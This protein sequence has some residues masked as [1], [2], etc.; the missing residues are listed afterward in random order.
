MLLLLFSVSLSSESFSQ[1]VGINE[2]GADPDAS[3]ILDLSATNKGLL[4]PRLTSLQRDNIGSPAAG[5][6]IYNV[7]CNEL[8]LYNGTS[9]ID[10]MGN[11]SVG[12]PATPVATSATNIGQTNFDANWTASSGATSYFIDVDD[13]SDFSSPVSG[14][15]NLN[16]GNVTT[17]FI[18]GLTCATNYYYRVGASNS[19]NTGT[20]SGTIT[21]TTTGCF[22]GCISA[23]STVVQDVTN[24]STGK[25]W[26]DRNLGASQVATASNDA[27][28]Y[29]C[30]YQWGRAADGHEDRGSATTAVL[31]GTDSP[32]HNNFITTPSTPGDWRNPKNDNLWQGVA[33]INNPCPA[34]YR[35]PTDAELNSERLSWGTNNSSGAFASPLKMSVGGDRNRLAGNISN[36][37]SGGYHWSSTVNG[38]YSRYLVFHGGTA[39]VSSTSRGDG[40]AVRC[41]K[42]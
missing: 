37:G 19:C 26:M 31:S 42:N 34:G 7:D 39:L 38:D 2:T 25:T 41:I 28:A 10:M 22:T 6:V 12:P 20:N 4:F 14:Y 17:Y 40:M 21:A 29:G 36:E 1:N 11:V 13:N 33:G 5:L 32:G 18:S 23:G 24:V 8:N 30:L 3:A 35:I 15:N 9:W 27:N 16:V